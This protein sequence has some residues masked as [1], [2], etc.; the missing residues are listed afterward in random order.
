[1]AT[2]MIGALIQVVLGLFPGSSR[3]PSI[4][5]CTH[6]RMVG[7]WLPKQETLYDLVG[8]AADIQVPVG[9]LPAGVVGLYPGQ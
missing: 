2:V 8:G 9:Y 5:T 6:W 1:M 7:P 3:L 4:N